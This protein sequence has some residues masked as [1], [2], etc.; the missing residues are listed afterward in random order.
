MNVKQLYFLCLILL[1]SKIDLKAEP[2]KGEIIFEKDTLD[3]T[4][5]IE[6]SKE[7][8][9]SYAVLEYLQQGVSYMNDVEKFLKP[10]DA[11]SFQFE[12]NGKFYKMVSV[13]NTL[14]AV[15]YSKPI[16]KVFLHV[17]MDGKAK[18]L[19]YYFNRENNGSHFGS[20]LNPSGVIL[21]IIVLAAQK[22]RDLLKITV[23]KK[24]NLPLMQF[25]DIKFKETGAYYF[26]DCPDLAEKIK[27]KVYTLDNLYTIVNIYNTTCGK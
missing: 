26:R 27:K 10:D 5:L 3:V 24:G 18:L 17:D 20:P 19:N 13:S 12:V 23:L 2:I 22:S 1:C 8:T 4:F 14:G 6:L 11:I 21:D 9:V 7:K 25:G 16:P 15:D